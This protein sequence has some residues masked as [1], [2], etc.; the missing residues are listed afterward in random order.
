M[1]KTDSLV[2]SVASTRRNVESHSHSHGQHRHLSLPNEPLV[3]RHITSYK[4][5]RVRE[6]PCFSPRLKASRKP[7]ARQLH[8]QPQTACLRN[9]LLCE[10]EVFPFRNHV[11]FKMPALITPLCSVYA[12]LE[13]LYLLVP[14]HVSPRP[15]AARFGIARCNWRR[16][17]WH[18][19]LARRSEKVSTPPMGRWRHGESSLLC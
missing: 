18:W 14:F 9:N 1:K 2:Q 13:W 6:I 4:L 12:N 7:Y 19:G 5:S 16:R 11:G 10:V 17:L 8:I 3:H 15:T